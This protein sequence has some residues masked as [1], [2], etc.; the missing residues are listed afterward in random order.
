MGAKVPTV[1]SHPNGPMQCSGVSRPKLWPSIWR[2]VS[3]CTSWPRKSL[4]DIRKARNQARAL[5]D[6]QINPNEHKKT[7][8]TQAH[9]AI[10]AKAEQEKTK[11]QTLTVQENEGY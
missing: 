1:K 2:R 5:I 3:K 11:V 10:I 4:T 9:G 6:E 8:K 7:T